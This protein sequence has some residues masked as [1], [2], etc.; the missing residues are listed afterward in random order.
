M[1]KT[2]TPVAETE[3]EGRQACAAR[4]RSVALVELIT[5]AA[6]ALSTAVA[7][8]AVSIGMARAEVAGVAGDQSTA[9]AVALGIGLLLWAVP[10]LGAIMAAGRRPH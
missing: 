10:V 5:T 7:A 9:F 3:H 1:S 8:T 4:H 6:L 2:S